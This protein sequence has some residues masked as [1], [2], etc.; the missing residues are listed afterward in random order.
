MRI[1][2][3]CNPAAGRG[4]A[5]RNAAA[6]VPLLRGRGAEV[7]LEMTRDQ[8]HLGEVINSLDASTFDRLAV[9]GGDG[10]LHHLIRDFDLARFDLSILPSGS[11]DDFA[12]A[13]GIPRDLRQACDVVLDGKVREIDVPTING[14]RFLGVASFGFDSEVA[15]YA[16]TVKH[17]RGSLVYLWSILRVLP[18]FVPKRVTIESATG[19]RNEEL[20]FAV[21][22][23]SPRYGGGI[24]IAPAARLDD[25]HL[26]LYVIQRCSR[27]RLLRTLPMAYSGKH[28]RSSFVTAEQGKKFA[29]RSEQPLDIF[30]DGEFV[31]T[32]PATVEMAEE[33]LRVIVPKG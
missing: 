31:T 10:T 33:K 32:T 8:Q 17:L 18:R 19:T 27:T 1:K 3:V 21:V 23:N 25:Q 24:H 11:G 5:A 14:R 16:S 15:R 20:M 7:D 29:I 4:K 22:A 13:L 30:A 28:V 2:L 9:L 6:A 26:D 12:A